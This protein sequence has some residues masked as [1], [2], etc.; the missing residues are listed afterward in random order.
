MRIDIAS[1]DPGEKAVRLL[2]CKAQ[3][4]HM[5]E[6]QST[7]HYIEFWDLLELKL[8]KLDI[9]AFRKHQ[10]RP[11]GPYVTVFNVRA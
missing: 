5:K 10:G 9:V 6:I 2:T 7:A 3:I 8:A 11:A 1:A 4:L